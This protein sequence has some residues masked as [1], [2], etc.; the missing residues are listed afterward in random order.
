MKKKLL[1]ALVIISS[2]FVTGCWSY[3]GLDEITIVTGVAIDKAEENGYLL[4]FEVID[5]SSSGKEQGIVTKLI[6]S[7]GTTVFDAIRN[8]KATVSNKLYFSNAQII[9]ISNEIASKEGISEVLSFFIRD[10][11]IRETANIL[12]SQEETAASILDTKGLTNNIISFKILDI[13]HDSEKINLYTTA[14]RLYNVINL[15]NAE[16]ASLTLPV[17]KKINMDGNEVVHLNG[18]ATFKKDKLNGYLSPDET[19]YFLFVIDKVEGGI[20]TFSTENDDNHNIALEIHKNK[21]GVEY[22]YHNNQLK[23]VINV[24]MTALLGEFQGQ[25]HFLDS[26]KIKEL[27]KVAA[28]ELKSRIKN[29]IKTIQEKG[30]NDILGFGHKIY[31]KDPK[32]WR[33]LKP[34][35]NEIFKTLDFEVN[36]KVMLK[37]TAFLR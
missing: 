30:N 22:R 18:L 28:D 2:L 29:V 6:N 8:A 15:L 19:K 32:L 31:Q 11:E 17:F 4:T 27:E 20:F 24:E 33:K 5:L 23:F 13:I 26:K 21:T 3:V 34:D 14:I 16:G 10:A 36:C 12:I 37:N 35:W 7:T 25:H 1:I 9:V